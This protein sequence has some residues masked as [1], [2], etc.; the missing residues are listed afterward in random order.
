[1]KY[2]IKRTHI[3]DI[4]I[5]DTVEVDGAMRTVCHDNLKRGFMGLTLFGDSY[6]L[7]SRMVNLAEI[8]KANK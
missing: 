6:R 5:G 8:Q 7:G 1:M 3:A 2:T 4:R